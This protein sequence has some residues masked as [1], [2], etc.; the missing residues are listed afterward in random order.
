MQ[1][2]GFMNRCRACPAVAGHARYLWHATTRFFRE[3]SWQQIIVFTLRNAI[4]LQNPHFIVAATIQKR[5]SNNKT[6]EKRQH[7]H[8]NRICSPHSL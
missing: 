5:T 2:Q 4:L 3:M 7:F 6:G 1:I 8:F